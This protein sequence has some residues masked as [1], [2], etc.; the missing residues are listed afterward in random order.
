MPIIEYAYSI[1]LPNHN[2]MTMVG[3]RDAG[4]RNNTV[5]LSFSLY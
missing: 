1:E 2:P 5:V 3:C 4:I